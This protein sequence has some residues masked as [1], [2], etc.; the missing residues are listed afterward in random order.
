MDAVKSILRRVRA[1]HVRLRIHSYPRTSILASATVR[2]HGWRKVDC[3]KHSPYARRSHRLK[4][5]NTGHYSL[6]PETSGHV[7]YI[8]SAEYSAAVPICMLV[9]KS[10]DAAR[11]AASHGREDLGGSTYVSR[12]SI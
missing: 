4:Q 8:S 3:C 2:A 1:A 5:R 11:K 10:A 9:V 6:R 7:M 12:R